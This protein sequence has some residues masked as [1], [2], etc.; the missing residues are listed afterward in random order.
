MFLIQ[1]IFLPQSHKE[2]SLVSLQTYVS[3]CSVNCPYKMLGW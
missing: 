3:A 1:L 2:E